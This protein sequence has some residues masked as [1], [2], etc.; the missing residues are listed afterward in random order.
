MNSEE[1][2]DVKCS[3]GSKI[4]DYVT[5]DFY[6]KYKG[7]CDFQRPLNSSGNVVINGEIYQQTVK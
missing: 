3:D 5:T 6:C 4:C 7:K 1:K 2:K